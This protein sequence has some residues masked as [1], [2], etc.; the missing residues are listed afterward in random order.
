[1]TMIERF[2]PVGNK[3]AWHKRFLVGH[4]A[5]IHGTKSGIDPATKDFEK[6]PTI[7]KFCGD[8]GYR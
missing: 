6:Y 4:A 8:E 2:F 3:S 5:N 1:M 7:K